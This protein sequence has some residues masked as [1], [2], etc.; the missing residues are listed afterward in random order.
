VLSEAPGSG[1]QKGQIIAVEA[2]DVI[3]PAS[4]STPQSPPPSPSRLPFLAPVECAPPFNGLVSYPSSIT[5]IDGGSSYR[6]G[7]IV[8][9]LSINFFQV[10]KFL[11]P[12]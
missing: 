6:E 12:F 4:P 7:S 2:E 9:I 8:N 3:L 11:N 10:F 5:I 1:F